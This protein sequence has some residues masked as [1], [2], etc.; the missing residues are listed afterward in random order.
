MNLTWLDWLVILLYVVFAIGVGVSLSR[1]A[2]RSV[3]EYFLS[4]RSLPWWIAGTSMVATSFAAD[5]PL[6]VSGWV[7]E[8]GIWKNWL[9]WCYAATGMLGVFLFSR[10]WR[11]GGF[12]TKAEL[13]ELRYG[14]KGARILRGVLAALHAGVINIM[15]LCWVMLAAS[16]ILDVLFGVENKIWALAAGM[17]LAMSYSLL[18][19]FWGVVLTDLVQFTLSLIGAVI[20]AF[21]CWSEVGGNEGVFAALESGRL[22]AET[23]NYFPRP[24]AGTLLDASFWTVPVAALAVYLGISWWAVESVDGSGTSVQRIS[25]SRD[26]RQG[27]LAVLWFNVAHYG[28][29]PWPWIL[30]GV[31]SLLVL[32]HL[33]VESPVAGHVVSVNDDTVVIAPLSDSAPVSVSRGIADSPDDWQPQ[34]RVKEGTELKQGEV[35]ART[36]SE[37]AY[38]VMML[39]YLPEGLLGLVAASLLAAFMSTVDT[40][41]NLASSFFVNDLYRRFWVPQEPAAHY[42]WVARMASIVIILVASTVAYFSNSI[43]GLFLFFLAFLGGV[44]PIY[45]LRWLWWRITAVTEMVAMA[46]SGTATILLTHVPY[47]WNLGA[48][49]ENGRL[50]PEGRLLLVA[51]TSLPCALLVTLL[52]RPPEAKSLVP[53]YRKVRPLGAWGPVR[54][55]CPEVTVQESLRPALVGILGGLALIYGMMFA[56]GSFLLGSTSESLIALAV[57]AAGIVAVFWALQQRTGD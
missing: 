3:E 29:R 15:V 19:G 52:M 34:W 17:L 56:T 49:S 41:M 43:S 36:D 48:F 21:I 28:L 8:F 25:A 1:R 33:S 57:M 27:M 24:G 2:S 5:T 26:E 54:A 23:L 30:V 37:R 32:P 42:V 22:S 4:G 13:V 46:V 45:L 40:H 55:F 18:S 6:V 10:W 53:F 50:V 38:V 20:L 7:R 9:W 39:R 14:G 47:T 44:G 35:M 31:A 16:K 11:R 51:L 12:M